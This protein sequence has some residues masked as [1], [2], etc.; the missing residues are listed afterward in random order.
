MPTRFVNKDRVFKR[1]RRIPALAQQKG[2]EALAA[3][4]ADIVKMQKRLAPKDSGELEDSI[5]WFPGEGVRV[6]YQFGARRNGK[7]RVTKH[8][9]GGRGA[10]FIAAGNT[11]VR[12]AH[13]VEFG[14]AP[15]IV[16][17]IFKGAQHPGTRAQPFFM[18]P[19][20]AKRR[21]VKARV[22]R[23]LKKAILESRGS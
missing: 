14:S 20:R 21:S 17:G 6:P 15:H 9:T 8:Q 2:L 11:R 19:W 12:Y 5:Q 3:G 23:A 16:G 18:G 10:I 7:R 22:K 1:L 4:A 13:I